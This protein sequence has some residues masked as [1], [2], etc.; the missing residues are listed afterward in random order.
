MTITA[1]ANGAVRR[2]SSFPFNRAYL[3]AWEIRYHEKA[4]GNIV[5]RLVSCS[6]HAGV[7]LSGWNVRYDI[8]K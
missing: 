3:R 8:W 6:N 4:P 2:A 5:V 7:F 1:T